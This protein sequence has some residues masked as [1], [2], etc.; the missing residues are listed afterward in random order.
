MV[1]DEIG[2]QSMTKRTSLWSAA[3]LPPLCR[4]G[5]LPPLCVAA[6]INQKPSPPSGGAAPPTPPC[7]DGDAS[8]SKRAARQGSLPETS[9]AARL[10]AGNERRGKAL[11]RKRA[12]TT[13][14]GSV[15]RHPVDY[16]GCDV[17]EGQ[18]YAESGA[19][20][21]A[22]VDAAAVLRVVARHKVGKVLGEPGHLGVF[23]A[24]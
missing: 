1:F 11:C 14:G 4:W 5:G 18:E 23:H 19:S 2:P 24:G 9:G 10:S 21:V 13:V 6:F 8:S 17:V 3:A 7:C 16:D 22:V 20:G 12:A 15:G